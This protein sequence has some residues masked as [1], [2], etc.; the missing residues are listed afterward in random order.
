[1]HVIRAEA[2]GQPVRALTDAAGAGQAASASIPSDVLEE[3]PQVGVGRQVGEIVEDAV[4][5]P[6]RRRE[7]N[8]RADELR[9]VAL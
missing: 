1:M 4:E 5:A 7:L 3:D 6:D 9:R 8:G 2:V